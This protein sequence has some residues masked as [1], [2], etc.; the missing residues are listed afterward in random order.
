MDERNYVSWD[1]LLSGFVEN[2]LVEATLTF[3]DR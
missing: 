3:S 1:A 2:G